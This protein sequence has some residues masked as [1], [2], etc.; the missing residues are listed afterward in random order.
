VIDSA[1]GDGALDLVVANGHTPDEAGH[2]V[3]VFVGDGRGGFSRSADV[4]VGA[5]TYSVAVGDFNGDG[6]LDLAAIHMDYVSDPDSG[7]YYIP[8]VKCLLGDGLG[9]FI[10]VSD[11]EVGDRPFDLHSGDRAPSIVL[12]DFNIDGVLDFV[13]AHPGN[14]D[15]ATFLG[16]APEFYSRPRGSGR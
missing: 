11:V 9:G 5:Y 3:R 12:G 10:E 8:F 1:N 13:V 4:E 14:C 15:V 7:S 2:T 16:N 6:A